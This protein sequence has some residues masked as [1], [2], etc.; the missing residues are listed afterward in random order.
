M[1]KD[2]ESDIIQKVFNVFV[3]G[4]EYTA[5]VQ[6][7]LKELAPQA[8]VCKTCEGKNKK[9]ATFRRSFRVIR[10]VEKSSGA[11][12]IIPPFFRKEVRAKL[13]EREIFQAICDSCLDQ[14]FVERFKDINE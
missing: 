7:I 4:T 1:N 6:Y 9:E 11:S 14:E 12:R 3:G 5:T 13:N 10:V 8:H 2:D